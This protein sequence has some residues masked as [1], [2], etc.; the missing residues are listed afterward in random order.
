MRR[1]KTM[2][3]RLVEFDMDEGSLVERGAHPDAKVLIKKSE[4]PASADP[5]WRQR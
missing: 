2:P 3:H 1:D 5:S 4:D